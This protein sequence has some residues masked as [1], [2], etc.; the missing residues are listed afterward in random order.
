MFSSL[1]SPSVK[2]R[3]QLTVLVFRENDA[4]RVF[5]IPM[6]WILQFGW[7]LGGL[8]A[9]VVIVLAVSLYLAV[10]LH[11]L[12]ISGANGG[13]SGLS[14]GTSTTAEAPRVLELEQQVKILEQKLASNPASLAAAEASP[15]PIISPDPDANSVPGMPLATPPFLFNGLPEQ[16]QAPPSSVPITIT[17]PK[18]RWEGKIL[19]VQF[20]VQYT[21]PTGSQQGRIIILAR[22]PSMI[23]SY[24]KKAFATT[25]SKSLI[26][27]NE[28]EYFSV[29]RFRKTYASFGP[30]IGR[31]L[32][33]SV[34]IIILAQNGQLLIH[35]MLTPSLRPAPKVEPKDE[36]KPE[37]TVEPTSEPTSHDD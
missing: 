9:I 22:G 5:K 20:G 24:P 4:A 21:N 26:N 7:L 17:V 31:D 10:H 28:G 15:E 1:F 18:A 35:Q 29:S 16:I 30:V 11:F 33:E 13:N 36:P 8:A 6:R 2:R 14:S 37:P 12:K 34:E 25:G 27:P 3:E 32:I 23:L 19:K